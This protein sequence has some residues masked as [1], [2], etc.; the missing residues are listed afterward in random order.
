MT[1]YCVCPASTATSTLV[2]NLRA[3][4][5]HVTITS[6]TISSVY[7]GED[8]ELHQALLLLFAREVDHELQVRR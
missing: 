2:E 3:L 1:T 4:G 5:L 8:K 7:A 6:E